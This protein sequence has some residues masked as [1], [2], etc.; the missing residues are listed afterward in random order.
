[1]LMYKKTESIEKFNESLNNF[2]DE[3]LNFEYK[4]YIQL[5]EIIDFIDSKLKIGNSKFPNLMKKKIKLTLLNMYSHKTRFWE[6]S[7]ILFHFL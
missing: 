3:K 1:M 6:K 2:I 7:Q 5:N 4:Y